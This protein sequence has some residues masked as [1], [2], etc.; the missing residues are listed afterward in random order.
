MDFARGSFLPRLAGFPNVVVGRTFAKAYGLAALR[1]GCVVARPEALSVVQRTIP[2]YSLNVC[3]IAGTAG[4]DRRPRT[5]TTAYC[6]QVAESRELVYDACRRLGL[7]WWPSEANFV[8]VRVGAGASALVG[9]LAQRGI[10][11]RDRSGEPGCAGC[12]R[13]TAGVV[14]HT[15]ACLAAMEEVLCEAR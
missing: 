8:L 13:I 1:I 7:G 14:E 15:R 9:A 3:A 12:V 5:T 6:A 4:G 11:I 2:P 10:F